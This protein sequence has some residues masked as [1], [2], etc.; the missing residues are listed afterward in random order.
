MI[1][2]LS[3]CVGSRD[4]ASF[5]RNRDGSA[6]KDVPARVFQMDPPVQNLYLI[7]LAAIR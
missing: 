1:C 7:D 5:F 6:R 4:G 2:G 3:I